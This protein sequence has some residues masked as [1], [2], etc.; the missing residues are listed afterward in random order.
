LLL[1]KDKCKYSAEMKASLDQ[2]P[3]QS[4]SN[5]IPKI[6]PEETL[7]FRDLLA[8]ADGA[9]CLCRKGT[10]ESRRRLNGFL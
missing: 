8:H 1:D 4:E 3:S 7:G 9:P 2:A 10:Y 5:R 6:S